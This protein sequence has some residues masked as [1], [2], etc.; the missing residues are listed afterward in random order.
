MLRVWDESGSMDCM[1]MSLRCGPLIND[2]AL[3]GGSVASLC[4]LSTWFDKWR[5]QKTKQ[6]DPVMTQEK[7]IFFFSFI[8]CT[9]PS[10]NDDC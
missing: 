3:L 10:G 4:K 9:S 1:Q 5:I 7:R 2:D 8:A 6:S